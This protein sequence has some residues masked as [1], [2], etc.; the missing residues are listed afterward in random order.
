MAGKILIIDDDI[1]TLR[2]VGLMLQHQ[3]YEIAAAANGEQGLQK[4]E[5]ERPDVI[6]LDVMMPDMDGFEVARR[7]RKSS[8]TQTTPILMFTAKSQL[9]DKVT[10][11]EVGADD[12]L[13]KPTSPAELQAHVRQ[14]LEHARDRVAAAAVEAQRGRVIAVLSAH[15]GLGVS[16]LAANL[17]AALQVRTQNDV[18]LAEF[19]PG[20]GTLGSDLGAS[21]QKA[22]GQLLTARPEEI[23][24]ERVGAAL[25]QHSSG[26]RLLTASENLRDVGLLGQTQQFEALVASLSSLAPYVVLD[27][28]S[29]LSPWAE[30]ILPK[31]KELFL[32]AEASPNNITRTRHL[33]DQLTDLKIDPA[34]ITVVLNTRERHKTQLPWAMAQ[35]SL[36]HPV[37]ADLSPAP[38]LM[39]AATQRH[40]PAVAAAPEHVTSQQ[41]LKLADRTLASEIG[42]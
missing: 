31:C 29:A 26:L 25:I 36:G 22:L 6:L 9:E 40:L 34:K 35:Q 14:L 3:G 27:L 21:D 32:V 23:T 4:A 24:P 15:G 20:Q 13:T 10:G 12:Y 2:L 38:E 8:T 28:G 17:A 7:L 41:I 1:D 42:G 19:R 11:F 5:R 18:I 39:S 33:I 30:K 37:T 16:T